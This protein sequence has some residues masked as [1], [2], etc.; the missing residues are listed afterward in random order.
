MAWLRAVREWFV[1]RE[2]QR[3]ADGC[4]DDARAA[5]RA[6]DAGIHA[7]A[8]MA[9]EA[10]DEHFDAVALV[11]LVQALQL[12]A[13]AASIGRGERPSGSV[14]SRAELAQLIESG[15]LPELGPPA[16]FGGLSEV[17]TSDDASAADRLGQTQRL[18]AIGLL[19]AALKRVRKRYEVRSRRR[20]RVLRWARLSALVVV[21]LAT[22]GGGLVWALMPSNIA[23]GKPV[24]ASSVRAGTPAP[25]GLTDGSVTD[26]YGGH[27]ENDGKA[28]FMLDLL[29]P[30]RLERVV[31]YHRGD[32]Y[33]SDVLPLV[34]ELSM[35]G[36]TF[37]RAA[38]RD[39]TFTHKKPWRVQLTG[40][41]ARYV[42][43]RV[44]RKDPSSYLALGEVEAYGKRAR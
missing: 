42:R 3:L 29:E 8:K 38:V 33:H 26:G 30:H 34:L 44:D 40:Q 41:V 24:T 20:I 7:R 18:G 4:T 1:L 13:S 10:A 19:F 11:L 12:A 39:G 22:L 27:T 17:I 37:Q 43:L 25:S 31:V 16:S 21:L 5:V 36:Q 32:G 23:R 6:L 15:E 14:L 35:D 28:W 2:A 9:R